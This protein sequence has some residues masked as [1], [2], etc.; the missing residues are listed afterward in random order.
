MTTTLDSDFDDLCLPDAVDDDDVLEDGT[1]K[2]RDPLEPR[3]IDYF[4]HLC[5]L[6]SVKASILRE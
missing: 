5:K 4:I 2:D 1:L 6:M 3:Q